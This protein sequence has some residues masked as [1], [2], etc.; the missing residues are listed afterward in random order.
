MTSFEEMKEEQ[1]NF[2]NIAM[3]DNYLKKDVISDKIST[4]AIC[5]TIF[6]VLC[7]MCGMCRDDI[8]QAAESAIWRPPVC[9]KC[10][11]LFLGNQRRC[12]DFAILP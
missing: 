6:S 4:A 2:D 9:R 3:N 5:K 7:C 11:R 1:K 10:G 12:A 8:Y